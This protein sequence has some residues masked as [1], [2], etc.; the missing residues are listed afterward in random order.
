MLSVDEKKEIEAYVDKLIYNLKKD[1]ARA[2][3]DGLSGERLINKVTNMTVNKL[4]PES[5]MILASVYDKMTTHTLAEEYFSDITHKSAFYSANILKELNQKFD[6]CVPDK[7]E[8]TKL[9]SDFNKMIASGAVIVAGGIVSITLQNWIPVCIAIVIGGI[10][11]LL[12]KN[13]VGTSSNSNIDSTINEYYA[14]VKESLLSWVN[15]VEA[16]YDK[17][18]VEIKERG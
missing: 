15:S 2:K 12:L 8:T 11:A 10:M 16:Y 3:H 14:T 4:T 18:I 13:K 7:I 6:F 9:N 1:T 17:K 5:K